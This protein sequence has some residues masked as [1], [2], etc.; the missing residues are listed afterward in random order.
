VN[1]AILFPIITL[2]AVAAGAAM[3]LF[4]VAKRFKVGVDRRIDEVTDILPG[5]NCGG[6]GYPG[7]RGFAEA[8]VEAADKGDISGLVCPVG[9]DETMMEVGHF[10]GIEMTEAEPSTVVLRCGGTRE[11]APQKL[12]YDGPVRCYISHEIFCGENGCSYGCVGL[13]DCVAVCEFAAISIDQKTSLPVV[14]VE[15]C[16]SCGACVKACP[17]NILEIRPRGRKDRRVWINCVN[18]EKGATAKK[19]CKAACIGCGLCVKI[20]PEKIGAITMANNVA[21]IDPKKCIACGLCV[22]VCPTSAIRATFQPPKPKTATKKPV[23]GK[24][25][26]NKTDANCKEVKE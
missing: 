19:N 5:A 1:P 18:M 17:R 9:S 13:G 11:K 24:T 20:C 12:K 4:L 3:I 25:P 22:P 10:L 6:C 26:Q 7:C 23:N 8:L 14:D 21:Y 15:K 16:V 2:G